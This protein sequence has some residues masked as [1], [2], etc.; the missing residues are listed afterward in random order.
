[1]AVCVVLC[2]VAIVCT[3]VAASILDLLEN[4]D[5]YLDKLDGMLE[6]SRQWMYE[7]GMNDTDIDS[8]YSQIPATALAVGGV[9]TLGTAAM[10]FVIILLFATLVLPSILLSYEWL[11]LRCLV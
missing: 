10:D 11:P 8:L 5:V 6:S 1:M 7:F 9:T 4:G 2:I 3:I